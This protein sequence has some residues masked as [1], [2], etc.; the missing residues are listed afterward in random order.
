MKIDAEFLS[1]HLRYTRWAS[2]QML[3]AARA[4]SNEELHRHLFSSYPSVHATLLH[5][6]RADRI[7][8]SRVV[9]RQISPFGQ[10]GEESISLEALERQWHA[11]SD[12]FIHWASALSDERID[13]A[14]N[15]VNLRGEAHTLFIWHIVLHVVNHGSYHRGQIT[16]M[17]RQLG[18]VPPGTDLSLYYLSPRETS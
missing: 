1:G 9:A 8:L 3:Q 12:E 4:L 14:L 11:V 13:G 17:L 18:H 2:D 7:W 15:Y 10:P 16:T 5:I 6:F